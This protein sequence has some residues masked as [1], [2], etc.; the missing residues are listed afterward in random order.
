[1]WF[2]KPRLVGSDRIE[3]QVCELCHGLANGLKCGQ[4]LLQT[5]TL[6]GEAIGNP[7][8]L[9]IRNTV[10][11]FLAGVPLRDALE[12][13]ALNINAGDFRQMVRVLGVFERTGSDPADALRRVARC[14]QER[15]EMRMSLEAKI[16]DARI[17]ATIVAALP[18]ALGVVSYAAQPRVFHVALGASAG[19]LSF[20]LATGLWITGAVMVWVIAH[21]RWL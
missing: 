12:E 1:V 13:A 6:V 16:V 10:R 3:Q 17:S 19:R 4:S 14:A 18:I 21:P 2:R 8:G 7:V 5:L 9:E 15:I 20:G 11:R